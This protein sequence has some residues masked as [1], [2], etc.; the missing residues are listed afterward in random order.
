MVCISNGAP[1]LI[2]NRDEEIPVKYVSNKHQYSERQYSGK[3]P[4]SRLIQQQKRYEDE[5]YETMNPTKKNVF[6]VQ[7]RLYSST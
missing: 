3:Q 2:W 6:F 7:N 4:W 1:K 5:I